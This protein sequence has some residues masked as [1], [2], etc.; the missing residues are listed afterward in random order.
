M[1]SSPARLLLLLLAALLLGGCETLGYYAQSA[2]GQVDLL[3]RAQDIDS[4]LHDAHTDE[5]LKARLREVQQ[6]RRFAV[7]QLDLPDNR[8]YQR[9]ADVEREALVW[10][11]VAAPALQLSPRQWCY[12]VIGCASYRGYFS[13]AAAQAYA[14][15]LEDEGFDVAVEP[16][17]AYSTLGWFSDPLPSTVID[18]PSADLAGLIFHELAHQRV[19]ARDDTAFNESYA[20]L[21]EQLGVQ[22]WLAA[23]D[24]RQSQARLQDWQRR[25][26]YTAQWLALLA[27]TRAR[28]AQVY[29][30]DLP[31]ARKLAQKRAEFARLQ[32]DYRALK[33]SWGGYAGFDRWMQRELNNAH[34]ASR[35]SYTRWLTALRRLLQQVDGDVAVFHRRSEQLAALS[36][37]ERARRLRALEAAAE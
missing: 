37:D 11:V 15:S 8:S 23:Q 29:Q 26:T 24:T 5:S 35:Q 14:A 34:L 19:Y 13:K 36:L 21:V 1:C 9:Y 12:P 31:P 25:E 27:E 16:V 22:R 6:M 17:P 20:S 28:L 4:L 33:A 10:S 3:C 30:A 32:R 18:W 7:G 2:G